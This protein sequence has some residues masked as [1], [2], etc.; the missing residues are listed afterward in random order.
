MPASTML[1]LRATMMFVSFPVSPI[2]TLL[3]CSDASA[4]S[5]VMFTVNTNGIDTKDSNTEEKR[6]K[7][8]KRCVS[9]CELLLSVDASQ[10]GESRCELIDEK[11]VLC[12]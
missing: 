3:S 4:N 5:K 11:G 7:R 2:Y 8:R 1:F 9:A 6:Q 12:R 10:K